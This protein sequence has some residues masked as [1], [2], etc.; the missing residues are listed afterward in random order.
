[1]SLPGDSRRRGLPG[2]SGP[3]R[4]PD[5]THSRKCLQDLEKDQ[6]PASEIVSTRNG[7]HTNNRFF[8]SSSEFTIGEIKYPTQNEGTVAPGMSVHI[9]ISFFATS[10]ADFDDEL[11]VVTEE[12]AFK[13]SLKMRILIS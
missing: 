4:V 10:L 13:V 6:V 2:L 8:P 12:N 9:L 7:I 1:M 3:L 11:G 5:L